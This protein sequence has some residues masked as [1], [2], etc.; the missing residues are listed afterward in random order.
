VAAYND[1]DHEAVK[2]DALAFELSE[3]FASL[4]PPS[5]SGA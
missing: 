1:L 5:G 3:D 2:K 4:T